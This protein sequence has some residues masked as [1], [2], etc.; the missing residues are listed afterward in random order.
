MTETM[1]TQV[2]SRTRSV[3]QDRQLLQ[4]FLGLP[5]NQSLVLSKECQELPNTLMKDVVFLSLGTEN[6]T[7]GTYSTVAPS[8]HACQEL[9][10]L[11]VLLG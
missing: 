4:Y 2:A 10:F 7:A 6:I 1:G 3:Y 5:V 9:I 11:I 8:D